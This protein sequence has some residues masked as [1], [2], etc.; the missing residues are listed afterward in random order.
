[1]N[2][3]SITTAYVLAVLPVA[4]KDAYLVWVASYPD[5]AGRLAELTTAVVDEFRAGLVTNPANIL[6]ADPAALPNA[7]A[8]H[9]ATIIRYAL[10]TEMGTELSTHTDSLMVRAEVF[11]RMLYQGHF[12]IESGIAGPT[13]RYE[14]PHDRNRKEITR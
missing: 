9:A 4:E 7:C 8:R 1:M 10:L 12:N 11:L 14:K 5:K 3:V 13:P 6:D 2:W